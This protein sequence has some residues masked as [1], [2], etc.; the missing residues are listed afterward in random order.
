MILISVLSIVS[1]VYK[2]IKFAFAISFLLL[3]SDIIQCKS[4]LKP[5]SAAFF[6]LLHLTYAGMQVRR[7]T[8]FQCSEQPED[9]ESI[10]ASAHFEDPSLAQGSQSGRVC[11]LFQVL[12]LL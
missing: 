7:P 5:A 6:Y 9:S 1:F 11:A 2:E 8:T 3:T 10:Q 4:N 12:P